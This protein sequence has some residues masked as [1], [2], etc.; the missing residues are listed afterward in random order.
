V[1]QH[2]PNPWTQHIA[3]SIPAVREC[4]DEDRRR[5]K[6]VA[7]LQPG[8]K[9]PWFWIKPNAALQKSTGPLEREMRSG[10]ELQAYVPTVSLRS[11]S[12]HHEP[13]NNLARFLVSGIGAGLALPGVFGR[14]LNIVRANGCR[15]TSPF[16][17]IDLPERLCRGH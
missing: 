17:D 5:L 11:V 9:W 16:V 7:R 1:V 4:A 15:L 3:E 13:W 6:G 2:L 12:F 10:A 14:N 8:A